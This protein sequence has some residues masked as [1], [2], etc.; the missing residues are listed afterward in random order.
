MFLKWGSNLITLMLHV[1]FDRHEGMSIM[2]ATWQSRYGKKLICQVIESRDVLLSK[3]WDSFIKFDTIKEVLARLLSGQL[4]AQAS[5][6]E[7]LVTMGCFIEE[8]E[9]QS[10]KDMDFD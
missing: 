1:T 9:V 10:S 3:E 5:E 8:K 7:T 4:M 2:E 6:N